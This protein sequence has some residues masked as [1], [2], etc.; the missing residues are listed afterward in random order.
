M[1]AKQVQTEME[2]RREHPVDVMVRVPQVEV[3][4]L[5]GEEDFLL[6]L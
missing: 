3:A 5:E 4:L 2:V 6:M 1:A